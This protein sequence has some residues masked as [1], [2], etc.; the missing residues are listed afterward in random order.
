MFEL[1]DPWAHKDFYKVLT[2]GVFFV[3]VVCLLFSYFFFFLKYC[4]F[5]A[6]LSSF[7]QL[8]I[9]V[10]ELKT[11]EKYNLTVCLRHSSVLQ[12]GA[13]KVLENVLRLDDT[14]HVQEYTGGGDIL[15]EV[16]LKV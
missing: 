15:S 7:C 12:E 16:N 1:K 4:F 10:S 3:V 9:R 13:G 14:P 8:E 2:C 5:F 6:L 11:K